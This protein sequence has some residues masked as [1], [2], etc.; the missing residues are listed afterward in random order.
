MRNMV[1]YLPHPTFRNNEIGHDIARDKCTLCAGY[2]SSGG[3][4]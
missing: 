2:F 1:A 3:K 4:R